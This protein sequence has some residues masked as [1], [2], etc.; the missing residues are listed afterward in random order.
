MQVK[1]INNIHTKT[2][3]ILSKAIKEAKEAAAPISNATAKDTESH[4]GFVKSKNCTTW[5]VD[6]M[7]TTRYRVT[8]VPITKYFRKLLFIVFIFLF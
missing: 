6:I 3:F 1:T 8:K 5:I 7:E 4:L 2:L